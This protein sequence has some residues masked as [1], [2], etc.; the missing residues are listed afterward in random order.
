MRWHECVVKELSRFLTVAVGGFGLDLAV[1]WWTAEFFGLPLWVAAATGF[2]VAAVV[3]YAA[4]ELW[5]FHNGAQRLS[6]ARASRYG[7]VLA[8]TLAARA[9]SVAALAALLGDSWVLPVLLA[10]AAVSFC[11]HYLLSK[12]FVFRTAASLKDLVS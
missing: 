10:G 4:H 8:A 11:V 2:A 5:T 3:N 1:S 7:L 9:G 6:I 12:Q